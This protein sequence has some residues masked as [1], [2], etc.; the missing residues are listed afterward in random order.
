MTMRA[1]D[2]EQKGRRLVGVD[3]G[4]ATAHTAQVLD[5]RLEVIAKRRVAPTAEGFTALETAALAGATAGTRL[6]V[7]IEPTGAAWLPVAVWFTARGHT[8]Y[9]VSS[10]KAADLRRFLSRHAKSNQIDAHT[11]ARLPLVDPGGLHPVALPAIEQRARLDRHVRATA[12]LSREI[13]E[14]KTRIIELARQAMPTIG[15]AL[16]PKL[17]RCD[18]AVLE[19]HGDPRRLAALRRDRLVALITKTSA[20][21]V[22]VDAKTDAFGDAAAAALAVYGDSPTVCFDALAEELATE[23]RLL[24]AAETERERHEQAREAAYRHVDE[25]QLLR[26]VPGFGAVGAPMFTAVIGD[27]RRFT[28]GAQVRAYVGLTPRASETGETDRKGQAI[29]KAGNRGAA[30]PAD[31]LRRDRPPA[32]PPARRRL[33]RPDGEQGRPPHQGARRR[34]C[35]ARR[36]R[37]ESSAPRAP[38]P[39]ARRRQRRGHRRAGARAD[40]RALHRPRR[41]P[42]TTA[43]QEEQREGPSH[44]FNA[45]TALSEATFPTPSLAPRPRLRQPAGHPRLDSRSPLGNQL[46]SAVSRARAPW[47][48]GDVRVDA[49][50]PVDPV[51]DLIGADHKIDA[52]DRTSSSKACTDTA[53]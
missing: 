20:G 37:L 35:Q 27:P 30:N 46:S 24:R 3:L 39:T 43:L 12:R 13:G 47:R 7:V 19:R 41:D 25:Q 48:V 1:T 21:R 22:D 16:S 32:R 18:L 15:R 6:E 40:H 10:Q 45:P 53:P 49:R 8:V 33:L 38:L 34:R 26:T 50:D 14:R 23:I 36:T 11:L 31:R 52:R 28:S 4:V 17:A 5:E 42:P 29:S 44:E 51:E 9:R 2:E